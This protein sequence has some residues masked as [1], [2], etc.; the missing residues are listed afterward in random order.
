LW[1]DAPV[2]NREN[3]IGAPTVHAVELAIV[4]NPQKAHGVRK[5]S[6]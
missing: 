3:K 6:L 4:A 5:F 2:M 1:R